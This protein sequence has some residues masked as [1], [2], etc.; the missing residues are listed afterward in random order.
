MHV[1]YVQSNTSNT[2]PFQNVAFVVMAAGKGQFHKGG[3]DI[4][5]PDDLAGEYHFS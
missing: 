5:D 3:H 2:S 4:R 1:Q